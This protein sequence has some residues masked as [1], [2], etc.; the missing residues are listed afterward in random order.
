MLHCL[1]FK[2]LD[3]SNR[4]VVL[5]KTLI[6]LCLITICTAKVIL[7]QQPQANRHFSLHY[8]VTKNIDKP[9]QLLD[10][11]LIYSQKLDQ[12]V[13]LRKPNSSKIPEVI[14][15]SQ[16]TENVRIE[17]LRFPVS[18]LTADTDYICEL[19]RQQNESVQIVSRTN[20]ILNDKLGESI[21]FSGYSL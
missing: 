18:Q 1:R 15:N 6:I 20:F 8:H 2:T 14:Q 21:V 16:L 17:E 9:I 7:I 13:F 19:R 3:Q 12:V 11:P 10:C 5:M 4:T